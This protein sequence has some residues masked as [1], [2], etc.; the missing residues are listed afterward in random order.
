MDALEQLLAAK[1]QE[2]GERWVAATRCNLQLSR[3]YWAGKISALSDA[4]EAI[5]QE[6]ERVYADDK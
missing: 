3:Q 5:R 6:K 1:Y 4:L 2:A